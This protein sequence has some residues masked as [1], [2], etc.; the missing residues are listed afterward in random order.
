MALKKKEIKNLEKAG[1]RILKAI[2]RKENIILFGD[3]DMDGISAVII[4]KESINILGGKISDI[5]FPDREKEGYGIT[6]TSL[7]ILKKHAPALFIV[8]DC[9]IGNFKE[10]DMANKM[11]FEVIVI[12]HHEILDKLPKASIIVDPKQKTD[13]YPFKTFATVGLS[14]KLSEFILKNKMTESIKKSFLELTAMA[15]IADMM[16]LKEDNME[17]VNKGLIDID[18]SWR[19]G[20]QALFE[21]K[22]FKGLALMEKV[23]KINSLLNIRDIE[24]RMPAAYR[25]LTCPD[26]KKVRTL[27]EKL[28]EKG[29]DRRKIIK[30]IEEDVIKKH[31]L[32]LDNPIIFESSFDWEVAFLGVAAARASQRYKKPAF[33]SKSGKKETQGAIRA[34]ENYN[35]VEAMK[36]CSK[37][38]ISYGGHP[39]AA[40]FRLKNENL[41]DFKNCLVNYYKK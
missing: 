31:L 11:K 28:Y 2:N 13:N 29:L 40:G 16:P 3:A 34:P 21:L 20:I 14:F 8:M 37:N 22:Y 35:V 33:L 30:E 5:Y 18:N 1:K 9:G 6:E 38:L 23:Y 25:I 24:K 12:D 17:L 4:L 39:Q 7:N 15:T 41:A 32:E 19:P 36:K 10:I 27:A 26:K